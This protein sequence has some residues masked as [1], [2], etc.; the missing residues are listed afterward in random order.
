MSVTARQNSTSSLPRNPRQHNIDD[1]PLP[2]H[3]HDENRPLISQEPNNDPPSCPE[4][5]P[6]I[7]QFSARHGFVLLVSIQIGSG[8]FSSPAQIDG[9]VA[10]PGAALLSWIASGLLAWT[11]ATSMAELG[12]ALPRNGGMQEYLRYIYGDMAAFLM[13]WIWIMVTKP[14]SMAILSILL[15]ESIE[16]A[17]AD[18][19]ASKS[20]PAGLSQGLFAVL[21]LI[22][23]VLLNSISSKMSTRLGEGFVVMKLA[24]VILIVVGGVAVVL[25]HVISP[26]K[27]QWGGREWY[28]RNWFQPRKSMSGEQPVDWP[29]LSM[30]ESLGH[31]SAAIYAGLWAYSGWDNA[32]FIA[33][34]MRNPGRDL[35][36]AIHAAMAVV[37]LC[38]E[39]ANASYYVL[40]PWDA[41]GSSNAVA[42]TAA[43]SLLGFPAAAG[44]AILVA[45]SC[46]GSISANVFVTARLTVAASKRGYLPKFFSKVGLIGTRG[47][48]R[49]CWPFGF[50]WRQANDY[51]RI[52][53]VGD[54]ERARGSSGDEGDS[55]NEEPETVKER[56]NIPVNAMLLNFL[57]TTTYILTGSFRT[58]LT[59]VGMAEYTFFFLTVVGLLILRFR[60]PEL[61][62][63][64]KPIIAVPVVFCLVSAAVLF[65]T[66]VFVPLQAV[67]LVL[68]FV[69][70]VV[71]HRC[72]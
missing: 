53:H 68:L 70:G 16:S 8:I 66:A 71:V 65:R 44:I 40:L 46:A 52:P 3:Q 72:R 49:G 21:A 36:I 60:E 38:F 14:A 56:W 17:I 6:I 64:Y 37:M 32:N 67:I 1:Q 51:V 18:P 43:R 19:T 59:F 26:E 4:S 27:A 62:R 54:S 23:V 69:G 29:R 5:G 30:W 50:P 35:P 25:R 7:R 48:G 42:V 20:P 41:L 15:M 13:A 63:P 34:E 47:E 58:L 33:G 11:G 9:N 12:A 31:Y 61:R 55:I 24:T 39:L 10:S 2:K 45:I 28:E 57:L 22:F